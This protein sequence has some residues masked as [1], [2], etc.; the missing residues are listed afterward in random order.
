MTDLLQ[1][2]L[3]GGH[4]SFVAAAYAVSFA[5]VA[6]ELT[7]LWRRARRAAEAAPPGHRP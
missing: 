3:S 5:L 7:L 4:E 2:I 1:R 6:L